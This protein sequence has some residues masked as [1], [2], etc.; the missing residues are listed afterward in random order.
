M[1]TCNGTPNRKIV[2]LTCNVD[3]MTGEE[4]G[5]AR[6][7]MMKSG[8]MEFYTVPVQMKKGRPGFEIRVISK[9]CDADNMAALL[10]KHSSTFGVR[11]QELS[12][13]ALE[14]RSQVIHTPFG[15]VR[16][17]IGEGYGVLKEKLE[18]DDVCAYAEK[19]GVD[20]KTAKR[21]IYALLEAEKQER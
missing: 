19:A 20:R 2:L 21:Q 13:Y 7:I 11:M 10:L 17:V 14:R 1:D 4:I 18:N 12:A 16:R 6:E 15:D 3:D 8:A 5:F 9:L